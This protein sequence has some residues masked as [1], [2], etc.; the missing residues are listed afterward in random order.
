MNLKPEKGI[1]IRADPSKIVH[2]NKYPRRLGFDDLDLVTVGVTT[3]T[4]CARNYEFRKDVVEQV[5]SP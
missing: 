1:P 3:V 2:Y 4:K 5:E